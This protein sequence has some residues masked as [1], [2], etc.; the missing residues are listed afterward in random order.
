MNYYFNELR[1]HKVN[2]GVYSFNEP[3]KRLHE[4]MGF[5]K[6]GQLIREVKFTNGKYWDMIIYGMTKGEFNATL[7]K[8]MLT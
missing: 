5:K 1:Y 2:A 3:S 8:D 4:K 6:E 7:G